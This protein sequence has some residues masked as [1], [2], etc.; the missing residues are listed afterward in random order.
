MKS[1]PVPLLDLAAQNHPLAAELRAAFDRVLEHGIFILGGEVTDLESAAA[2]TLG[3]KHAIGVSSGTDALLLALMALDIGPGDEVI[4]PSF[5]FFATAGAI[6]RLG[7]TPVFA[8]VCPLCFNLDP[9]SVAQLIT[10][11][12]KALIPVHLFGQSAPMDPLIAIARDHGLKVIEDAAQAFGAAY[13]GK[14][15]G[16]IGDFGCF[17]FFPSKNLGGFG[18][19]GLLTTND[20]ALADKARILRVHGSKPKYYHSL[21]GGNFR[22][23]ALQAALIGVKLPHHAQY[24]YARAEN[25][26]YYRE[27]LAPLAQAAASQCAHCGPAEKPAANAR[28]I[29]PQTLPQNTHIW[30]QFTLRL[31][32]PK[33]AAELPRDQLKKH[34]NARD[35]G[36]EIYYP[37]PFHLQKC[38]D[39]LPPAE[40]PVSEMLAREVLSIPIYPELT[41]DQRDAVV[42]AV[43]EFFA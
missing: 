3:A 7:A 36:A 18:D 2:E 33:D 34:L 41:P 26:A 1:T 27:A 24:S 9:E 12:T 14:A 16:T 20:D 29:L 35:I 17:S 22:L 4:C 10:P 25:A 15:L 6:A 5:S 19:G 28:L 21:I 8:D 43:T 37:V 11:K 13:H 40:C 38:F 31:P 30:N 32:A 39:Y 23:D 42:T